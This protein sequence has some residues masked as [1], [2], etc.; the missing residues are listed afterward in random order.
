MKCADGIWFPDDE[1]HLIDMLK[2]SPQVD[3]KGTYQHH[4][5]TAAL[6][7]VNHK[8]CALDI[9]MHVGLWAMHLAKTFD[10][11]IGFEPRA[12]HIECLHMNMKG[13]SNY[14]VHSCVLGD[15]HGWIE[16]G[17]LDGSTGSTHIAV[18]ETHGLKYKMHP[19]DHF[20]FKVVDFIKIDVEG[21]EYFVVKGGE[22]T[23]RTHQPVVILEQKPGKVE[24]YGR[25]QYDARDLLVSWGM[26]QRFE[27]KGD[28][29]L[30]W[31]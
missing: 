10:N 5:L 25:K 11:V 17:F 16:L 12:E 29:C 6:K 14:Q 19:L 22:R 3:G 13:L 28:C 7:F 9:G 27:I 23:I 18:T 1:R 8:R 20:K 2:G 30:T 4:K 15:R 24:W 31:H 21:Y 26:K